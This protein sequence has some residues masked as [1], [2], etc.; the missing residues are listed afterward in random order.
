MTFL[1]KVFFFKKKKVNI[2]LDLNSDQHKH[3]MVNNNIEIVKMLIDAGA[4]LTKKD[5]NGETALAKACKN[6]KNWTSEIVHLLCSGKLD[7][8][9]LEQ[10][11]ASL[12]DDDDLTKQKLTYM[13]EA[14]AKL[15]VEP[16]Q[17]D[18]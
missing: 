2:T 5:L 16:Q 11:I 4:D 14:L 7:K 8:D 18:R 3:N 13:K 17:K 6:P 10:Q 1:E 9:D 15:G 12:T